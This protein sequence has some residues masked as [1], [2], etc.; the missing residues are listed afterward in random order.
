MI[1]LISSKQKDFLA[2]QSG[3]ALFFLLMILII[4]AGLGSDIGQSDRPE[5]LNP[6]SLVTNIK[7]SNSTAG[8]VDVSSIDG[9]IKAIYD[10]I[11]FGQGEEPKIER[12]RSIFIPEARFTRITPE[13]VDRFD[14][15][16]FISSFQG[17]I[18]S[19]ALKSFFETE[20]ARRSESFGSMAQI[21]S[22]YRKGMNTLDPKSFV[23]GI[24][25]I[26]LFYDGQRWWAVSI[27]WEDESQGRSIPEKYLR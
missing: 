22:T 4:T 11:T 19:G 7:T 21:F 1:Q 18:K 10:S 15:E 25:S 5:N 24:N 16:G 23:R 17:R 13:K 12:F 27:L 6:S 8:E 9:I 2:V 3:R 20:I 26:Q 14:L